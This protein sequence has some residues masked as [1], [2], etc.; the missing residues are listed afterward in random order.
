MEAVPSTPSALILHMT[1]EQGFYSERGG[2][3]AVLSSCLGR[4]S[5]PA[6]RCC[7]EHSLNEY[8][9]M[10]Y[11]FRLLNLNAAIFLCIECKNQFPKLAEK[12]PF[13][14]QY[15]YCICP[16]NSK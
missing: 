3:I 9:L 12:T 6:R 2:L 7:P 5:Q 1:N 4:L 16:L 10:I 14:R 11:V 13:A 8:I 15:M